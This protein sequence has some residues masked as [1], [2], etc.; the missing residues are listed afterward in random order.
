VISASTKTG[1][2]NLEVVIP[3]LSLV[4]GSESHIKL[5]I[6][7]SPQGPGITSAGS[8][9]QV[10]EGNARPEYLEKPLRHTVP[11]EIPPNASSVCVV[12]KNELTG[13]IGSVVLPF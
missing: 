4:T 11:I 1:N 8:K 6:L 2:S 3:S 13:A 10:L 7:V 5:R 9:A 12:V